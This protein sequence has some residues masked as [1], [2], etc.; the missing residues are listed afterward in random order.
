MVNQRFYS[1]RGIVEKGKNL[2]Q[3]LEREVGR[4]FLLGMLQTIKK[5]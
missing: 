4:L 3:P 1:V 2:S 5:G